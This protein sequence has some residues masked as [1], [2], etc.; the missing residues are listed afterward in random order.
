MKTKLVKLEPE[1]KL[2]RHVTRWLISEAKDRDDGIE[3]VLS[4]LAHGCS[5]GIVRHLIR[6]IE[7]ARFYRAHRADIDALVKDLCKSTGQ[8][9]SRSVS[10]N[11]GWDSSDP[12]ARD[13]HN[14]TILA[15]FGFEEAARNL[16]ARAE[17]RF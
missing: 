16:A 1:T 13:D 7:C 5:S 6:T 9:F 11:A 15:W 14:Q 10:R 17:L 2:E 12:F 3:G 8:D 4:D